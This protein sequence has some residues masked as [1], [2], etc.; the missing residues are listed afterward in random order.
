MRIILKNS[1]DMLTSKGEIT[2][3][4]LSSER[5]NVIVKLYE[6]LHEKF[7]TA[8]DC[9]PI[10]IKEN[11]KDANFQILKQESLSM[12]GLPVDIVVGKK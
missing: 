1:R 9:R 7:P 4:S 6:K 10:Y 3:V 2:I 5:T 12:W 8:I 11:L